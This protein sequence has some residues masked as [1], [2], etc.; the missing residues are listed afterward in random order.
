M[1]MTGSAGQDKTVKCF[2]FWTYIPLF[3]LSFYQSSKNANK[4]IQKGNIG[5]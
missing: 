2:C 4:F 5:L 1:K 3:S